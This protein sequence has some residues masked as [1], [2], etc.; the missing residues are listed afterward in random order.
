MKLQKEGMLLSSSEGAACQLDLNWEPLVQR[1]D[2]HIHIRQ[3]PCP[4][5]LMPKPKKASTQLSLFSCFVSYNLNQTFSDIFFFYHAPLLEAENIDLFL[6]NFLPIK[7]LDSLAAG[8]EALLFVYCSWMNQT[9]Y[10][11]D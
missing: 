7:T 3:P 2:I 8:V 1:I 10:R 6:F 5:H 9:F 11:K 4:L